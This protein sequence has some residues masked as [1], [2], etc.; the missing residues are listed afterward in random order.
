MNGNQL[1]MTLAERADVIVDFTN[2]PAGNY[3]LGNA[4]PDEP[5]N[6]GSLTP[7]ELL[8]TGRIMQF[9]VG[10]A[11]APD[12]TTPPQFLV[13]PAITPLPPEVTTRRLA[14][15]EMAEVF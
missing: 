8:T 1:L 15:M 11:L 7:A 14:L 4:G 2:V 6:G 10:P 13:L 3:V 5:F 12:P 9:N